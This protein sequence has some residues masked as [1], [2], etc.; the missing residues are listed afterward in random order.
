[1]PIFK[2]P[3][4]RWRE[5]REL[6]LEAL[7]TDPDAFGASHQA[8]E[9]RPDSWWIGCL[10][11]ALTDPSRTLWFAEEDGRLIGMAGAYPEQDPANVNVTSMYVAPSERGKGIGRALLAAVVGEQTGKEVRLCVNG[12]QTAAAR[13]YKAFGF[14]TLAETPLQRAHGKSNVQLYMRLPK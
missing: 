9:Q 11:A 1:M 8:T 12:D 5:F 3:P 10:D 7:R 14:V 4:D 13:L 2:L 6:R